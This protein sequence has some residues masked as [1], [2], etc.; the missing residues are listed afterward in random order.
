MSLVWNVTDAFWLDV[1]RLN[2]MRGHGP[3][4]ST[5]AV[6]MQMILIH[7]LWCP[8]PK[9]NPIPNC[10]NIKPDTAVTWHVGFA[11]ACHVLGRSKR[12]T[13]SQFATQR[14]HIYVCWWSMITDTIIYNNARFAIWFGWLI[15]WF[16]MVNWQVYKM[17]FLLYPFVTQSQAAQA[18]IPLASA[19]G[20][21]W[22]LVASFC[23]RPARQEWASW[24][25]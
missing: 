18:L 9:F 3:R 17:I 25:S 22:Q 14:T 10:R 11:H 21:W 24:A 12:C 1:R 8:L 16:G 7:F 15:S 4:V 5:G 13:D 2:E 20:G 23:S 6:F 19:G